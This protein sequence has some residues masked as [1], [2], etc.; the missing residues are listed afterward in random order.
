MNKILFL[1]W[2]CLSC[3]LF[4]SCYDESNKYGNGLVDSVFRNISTDTSTVV[5]TSV[6][7]DSLETSGKGVALVG[8]YT[9]SIWG[10]MKSSGYIPYTRPSYS[11]DIDK[12]VVL[13]SLVL[14]LAYGSYYVGDT[15]QYQQFSV[16]R[17]TEKVVLNDNNYLYNTSSFSYETE[18]MATCRFRPRP[19]GVDKL[20]IR[21]PDELGQNLLTR[22]YQR[23]EAVSSERFEDY[24]KGIVII[25]DGSDNHSMLS[26]QV[27]DT[28]STIVLHYHIVEEQ[29]NEQQLVFSPNTS[30]QFNHID[31]DRTGTL[32]EPFP[33]KQVEI[34]SESLDNR[35]VLF[36][37]LGWFARLEFPYLNDIMKLGERVVIESAMLKLY[38]ELGTYSETNALPD[39]VYLYI[40]DENNVVTDAVTDYLGTQVQGG[41]LVKDD[42]FNENTYYYFDVTDFMQ[43]EL[44]TIGINKHNLQLVLNEDSYTKTFKNMTF[45]D[46]QSKSPIILQLIYKIYE[47]Y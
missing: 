7:I 45:G 1:F 16:H 20:E 6:L 14:S 18:P 11:T 10:T 24:F 5:I 17:L 33:T 9:H 39:S 19:Q 2:V 22:F 46:R 4:S 12:V 28:M 43:Q 38:P 3:C 36:G 40:A 31:H 35:G 27:A 34:P 44:G 41:T 25:P 37:G 8:E 42:V 23:D 13:D 21:L 29:A 47:S 15:L 26:F 30:T 32:M